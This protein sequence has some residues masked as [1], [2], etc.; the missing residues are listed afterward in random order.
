[1]KPTQ[2]SDFELE[3]YLL[4]ELSPAR[5]RELDTLLEEHDSIRERLEALK[6]SNQD[7]LDA[8]KPGEQAA[9]IARRLHVQRT[10]DAHQR[11]RKTIW[12][13]GAPALAAV[14]AILLVFMLPDTAVQ[15]TPETGHV[16]GDGV[17]TKGSPEL[18]IF[19][20]TGEGQLRIKEGQAVSAGD[21]LQLRYMAAGAVYG[22]V[23]SI[24]GSGALTLHFPNSRDDDNRLESGLVPL[25][26]AYELDDAPRFERFYFVTS[27]APFRP[28]VVL[29]RARAL[30]KS[31]ES[32]QTSE[33]ELEGDFGQTSVLLLKGERQ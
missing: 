15:V 10:K 7:I 16:I 31:G 30:A 1:M 5:M 24:D 22:T 8:H 19:K 28:G 23:F 20:A 18:H 17:R 27:D 4:R 14:A 21:S 29:D 2:P 9:A 3:R 13:V 12:W 11:R 32:Y 26:F 6:R 25:G 33:L